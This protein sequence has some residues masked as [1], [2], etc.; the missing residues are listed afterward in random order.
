MR[1]GRTKIAETGHAAP[2]WNS[3]S[4]GIELLFGSGTALRLLPD[5]V[6]GDSQGDSSG[7]AGP[8]SS[9]KAGYLHGLREMC[10][11]LSYRLHQS[12][13]AV[14]KAILLI[15]V[16]AASPV[17]AEE[18]S[19]FQRH[20]GMFQQKCAK[21][22]TVG[23]G[24]RVG[25]DLK[26]VSRRRDHQWL[27]GFIKK[28]SDYLNTDKDAMELL[29]KFNNS[30]M[31]DLNLTTADAEGLLEYI[32][33]ASEGPVGPEDTELPEQDPYKRLNM[34]EENR[35]VLVP[36]AIGAGLLVLV[37][38]VL[39][40]L[41]LIRIAAFVFALAL[42]SGYWALQGRQT[43]RLPSDQQGY[44][45][46]QPM[47][48]SHKK[49]AGTLRIACLYCHHAAE[50]S[51]V[52]GIPPANICMNCH[53]SVK[54]PKEDPTGRGEKDI[55][56]LLDAWE[57]RADPKAGKLEWVR[58]HDLPDYVQFSHRVHI[59]NNLK[60]QE[61]H[62]PVQAMERMRQAAPLTMGWCVDCHRKTKSEAPAHWKRAGAT[63]DCAVCH[64]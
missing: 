15:A 32:K 26:G 6:S 27:V 62:G 45:P 18:D 12:G 49:H 22:H 59:N 38:G 50:K 48:F 56:M 9:S 5:Q 4:S 58:V 8:G 39:F 21:C 31:D 64:L 28:P 24:D 53:T 16:F 43:H 30:R 2:N 10:P 17:F 7:P 34:P 36:L 41:G 29:K 57:N 25:P 60:C 23:K 11:N 1:D 44:E 37:S 19:D 63:L 51:D 47:E 20:A 35:S 55:K 42:G 46:V 14:L 54:K 3:D 61:C 33:A 40:Q 52:A 13:A